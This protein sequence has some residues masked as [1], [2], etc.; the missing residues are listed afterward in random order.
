[1]S[2]QLKP[3][4]ISSKSV[5]DVFDFDAFEKLQSPTHFIKPSKPKKRKTSK[6][7]NLPRK[8]IKKNNST[9][10]KNPEKKLVIKL[11]SE[12]H[13]ASLKK[14]A[15]STKETELECIWPHLFSLNFSQSWDARELLLEVMQQPFIER[16]KTFSNP[17]IK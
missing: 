3:P 8:L 4:V 13:Q 17:L 12:Q 5:F 11:T 1:M 7:S 10:P 6:T 15:N 16:K 14:T 2:V 9:V